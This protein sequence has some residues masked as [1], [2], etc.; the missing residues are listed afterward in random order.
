MYPGIS[1]IAGV[2]TIQRSNDLLISP[3]AGVQTM[4]THFYNQEMLPSYVKKG[5]SNPPCACH[6]Y[7]FGV[8]V[9]G[10]KT[11]YRESGISLDGNNEYPPH[12]CEI[13]SP[14]P[15][16]CTFG[17]FLYPQTGGHVGTVTDCPGQ[18]N[19]CFVSL[20]SYIF[21]WWRWHVGGVEFAICLSIHLS[22][23]MYLSEVLR[24][25]AHMNMIGYDLC[26]TTAPYT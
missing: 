11:I 5:P 19:H 22:A 23:G 1:S 24:L 14:T 10:T 26:D 8:L 3:T 4:S 2:F 12:L 25:T 16:F 7:P 15:S 20:I 6:L 17:H 9:A 21:N 18:S 13:S